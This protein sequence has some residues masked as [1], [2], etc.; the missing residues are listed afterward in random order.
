MTNP[1]LLDEIDTEEEMLE[2]LEEEDPDFEEELHRAVKN[3][4]DRASYTNEME[5]GMEPEEFTNMVQTADIMSLLDYFPGSDVSQLLDGVPEERVRECLLYEVKVAAEEITS[6]HDRRRESIFGFESGQGAGMDLRPVYYELQVS[7]DEPLCWVPEEKMVALLTAAAPTGANWEALFEDTYT[8]G[9]IEGDDN[10]RV[11][12]GL[13]GDEWAVDLRQ[14]YYSELVDAGGE[15]A[16]DAFLDELNRNYPALA[17]RVKKAKLPR[18]VLADYAVAYFS[19][20]EQGMEIIS[21]A[22][23]IFGYKGTKADILLEID[24]N[25]LRNL[26]ITEGRWWDGAPWKLLNL[27]PIELSYEGTLMRHCVGRFDMGYREAVQRGEAYIWSL[28]SRYN[29][30]ILTFEVDRHAWGSGDEMEGAMGEQRRGGAIEQL[31]GKM[32]RLGGS[33][34]QE[35]A[36]LLWLFRQLKV[37]P[38]MVHDFVGT[39]SRATNPGFNAPWHPYHQRVKGRLLAY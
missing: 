19:D 12:V 39:L 1:L 25:V 17:K 32:N 23:G 34:P 29:K 27:P 31:K 36:V 20:P 38:A 33:D 21:E 15:Q 28:R 37:D 35:A 2:A 10:W 30:P 24:K 8:S 14:D 3:V 9:W 13:E 26:G 6:H 22:T 11:K 18:D 4:A 16:T 5:A 7:L